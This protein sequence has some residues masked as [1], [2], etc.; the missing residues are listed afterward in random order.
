MS[1]VPVFVMGVKHSGTTI[2]YRMLAMHPDVAWFSQFSC[3]DGSIPGRRHI[4]GVG[5]LES[6]LRR[7]PH[8]WMKVPASWRKY[9]F[10][11]PDEAGQIFEYLLPAEAKISPDES[12][13]RMRRFFEAEC[14]RWGKGTIVVK[15]PR[16]FRQV[17]AIRHAYPT[18]PF[19]HII[20]D[21]RAVAFS[22][23]PR[24]TYRGESSMQALESSAR[25][26]LTAMA[27]LLPES[28]AGRSLDIG[29]E[30]FCTDVRG[31]VRRA[32]EFAGLDPGRFPYDKIPASLAPTNDRWLKTATRD[33]MELLERV[34]GDRFG[35]PSSATQRRLSASI[36]S[37]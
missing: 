35:R 29:Y 5:A 14:R 20:R 23:R 3:R 24:Y 9:Y 6:L 36:D 16:L 17:P 26:W 27:A 37:P 7:Q 30:D 34:L 19:V 21:G 15:L 10:P 22:V 18:A 13:D 25:L 1:V 11:L 33:E 12:A 32:V 8:T 2:L 31:W 28:E 4:P